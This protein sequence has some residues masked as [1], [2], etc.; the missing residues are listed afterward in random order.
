MPA[1]GLEAGG[2]LNDQQL[3]DLMNYLETIQ[4]SQEEALANVSGAVT[5]ELATLEG[6]PETIA[7]AIT[8]QEIVIEE[9]ET[10][11]AR[12]AAGDALIKQID[13]VLAAREQGLDTDQDGL[14]DNAESDINIISLSA[15]TD[16]AFSNVDA[17]A[18]TLV[19]DPNDPFTTEDAQGEPRSDL[20]AARNLRTELSNLLAALRPVAA[21]EATLLA[22]AEQTLV[23][24][25][26]AQERAAYQIDFGELAADA[27]GGDV[28]TAERAY[29]LYAA[30]CARCHT[31]GYSAGPVALK[32]PGS[33]AL[34]PSLRDG[35]TVV[36]FPDRDEHIEFILNG[37]VN[38]QGYGVNGIGRGWMPGFGNVLTQSDIELIVDFERSLDD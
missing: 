23:N 10:A 16:V 2:P 35:R 26:S 28:A 11:P 31:A 36:Q 33:G 15:Q 34:G 13:A 21:N 17:T 30:Y 19:L 18:L 9:V 27:F 7:E 5:A 29:G 22:A 20:A 8:E 6:A 1:W 25:L 4:I 32:E 12:L 38:G 14:S 3:N 24:L 37:S